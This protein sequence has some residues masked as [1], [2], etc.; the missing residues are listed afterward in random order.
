MPGSSITVNTNVPCSESGSECP[1]Q[2]RLRKRW[3]ERIGNPS[4]AIR[5]RKTSVLLLSWHP[6]YDSLRVGSEVI[7]DLLLNRVLAD[8][9]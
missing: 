7:D 9:L 3:E 6:D 1:T 8:L 5:H 4:R 2:D